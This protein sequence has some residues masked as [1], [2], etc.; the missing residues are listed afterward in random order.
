MERILKRHDETGQINYMHKN[1]SEQK[2]LARCVKYCK[3]AEIGA[4]ILSDR[5]VPIIAIETNNSIQDN[6]DV[7]RNFLVEK[8]F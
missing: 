6:M 8:H 4:K 2:L 7:I 1:L 5:G 3:Y